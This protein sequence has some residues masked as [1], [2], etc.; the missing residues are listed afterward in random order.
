MPKP[1]LIGI[2]GGSCSGKTL[3]AARLVERLP[4][5]SAVVLT[6]DSYYRDLSHL[7]PAERA[8]WN[9]DLPEALDRD[10]L[11][12]QLR[13]LAQGET[14]DRPEYDFTAH[15]RA[16]HTVRV[17]PR[18]FIL[19][20]GLFVLYWEDV[21]DL[22]DA[23]VFIE[24]ADAVCLERRKA[25]D[26]RERGRTEASVCEQYAT[27]VRPMYERYCAPTAQFADIVLNGED[28]IDVSTAT[29]LRCVLA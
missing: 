11:V 20:E 7:E 3:L 12:R 25:R 19:V 22:M 18:D 27:T 17:E 13:A 10:L 6:L 2:A 4:E 21:R 24:V 23:K 5:N 26:V 14:I 1:Y 15:T 8:R 9:F 16:Q 29:V 28:P